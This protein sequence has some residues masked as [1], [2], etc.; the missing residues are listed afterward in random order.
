MRN[1]LCLAV[2]GYLASLSVEVRAAPIEIGAGFTDLLLRTDRLDTTFPGGQGSVALAGQVDT[3]V[4]VAAIADLRFGRLGAKAETSVIRADDGSVVVGSNAFAGVVIRDVLTID[5]NPYFPFETPPGALVIRLDGFIGG[6]PTG[7]PA[8][9]TMIFQASAGSTTRGITLNTFQ[10]NC[11]PALDPT[12]GFPNY[13]FVNTGFVDE[14]IVVPFAIG[15]IG[16]TLAIEARLFV[17]AINGG[18]SIFSSTADLDLILPEGVTFTSQFG[19]FSGERNGVPII[20]PTM[21]PVPEPSS[22]AL[23]CAGLASLIG[24]GA[25]RKGNPAGGLVP[26]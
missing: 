26:A 12:C 14:T 1:W 22:L 13:R 6:D 24:F 2:A 20:P 10:A 11:Q 5:T 21:N 7:S 3:G 17:Q 23:L 25:A 19:L 8:F 9:A 15:Q 4:D 18:T 16:S